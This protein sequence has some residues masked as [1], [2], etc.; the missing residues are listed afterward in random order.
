MAAGATIQRFEI[1]LSDVD[2]GVYE[3]LDLRIAQH[4]SETTRYLLTRLVAYLLSHEDGIA[5]SKGGLSDT[6]DPPISIRDG[7]GNFIAWIDVGV[8]SGDRL[9]KASKAARRVVIFTSAEL[10]LLR[11]EAAARNIYKAEAIEIVRIDPKFL[12]SLEEKL[13]R[14]TVLEVT[15]NEGTLYVNVGGVTLETVLVRAPLVLTE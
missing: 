3:T 1:A 8:P 13:S 12:D 10:T 11:K 9:H 14:T 2:R 5:F 7:S 15:H 4:P 6:D